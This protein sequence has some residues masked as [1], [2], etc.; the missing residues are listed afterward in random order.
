LLCLTAPDLLF[1]MSKHFGMSNKKK[2]KLEDSTYFYVHTDYKWSFHVTVQ[3]Q[4]SL[5]LTE[6]LFSEI[7][8]KKIYSQRTYEHGNKNFTGSTLYI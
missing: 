2:K 4:L 1:C 6:E 3:W 5:D 7:L 8:K